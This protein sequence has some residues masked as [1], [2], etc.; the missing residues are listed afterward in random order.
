MKK[1][2]TTK[3]HVYFLV[4]IMLV[5]FVV[6]I[7]WFGDKKPKKEVLQK[8]EKI[9]FVQAIPRSNYENIVVCI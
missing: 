9:D 4:L 1:E 8:I 2:I 3:D 7:T 5:I 6:K